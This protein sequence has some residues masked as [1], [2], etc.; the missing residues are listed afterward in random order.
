VLAWEEVEIDATV[1]TVAHV[2]CALCD[3]WGD[4][5]GNCHNGNENKIFASLLWSRVH[6]CCVNGVVFCPAQDESNRERMCG[7]HTD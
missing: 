3:E 6:V 5:T 1:N 4:G 7:S 2:V